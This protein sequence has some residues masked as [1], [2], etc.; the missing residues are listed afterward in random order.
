[1]VVVATGLFAFLFYSATAILLAGLAHKI[2]Q[3]SRVPA[4]LKIPVTP[5]PT[6]RTGLVLRMGRELFFFE[7]LFRELLSYQNIFWLFSSS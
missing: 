4:P 7:S 5:A 3:Y 6:T 2:I 1:M